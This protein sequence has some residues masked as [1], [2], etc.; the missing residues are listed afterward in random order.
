MSSAGTSIS[1]GLRIG[2]D[3]GGTFTDLVLARDD[4]TLF[5]S[6]VSST[7]ADPG[8]AVIN[9]LAEMLSRLSIDPRNVAEIVHGTTVGSNA[10]LQ[11]KGAKTALLT[12]K[13]FRDV[14]EIGRIRTHITIV[15]R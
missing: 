4:R 15:T 5:V 6:K 8:E 11:R 7:P 9:G 2:V 14:L 3:I 13:G 12:T 1:E 10:I